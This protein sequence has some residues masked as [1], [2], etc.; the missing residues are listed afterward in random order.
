MTIERIGGRIAL[1]IALGSA[2]GELK[3]PVHF[4]LTA[5]TD[6][7]AQFENPENDFP[8]IIMYSMVDQDR[9]HCRIAGGGDPV[10]FNF[11][12]SSLSKMTGN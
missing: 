8:M 9:L 11:I 12:R 3:P 5:L 6:S 1:R 7:T 4:M 2:N 10:D